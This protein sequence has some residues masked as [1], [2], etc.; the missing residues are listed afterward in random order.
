MP[1]GYL[2]ALC[3]KHGQACLRL[4]TVQRDLKS[5]AWLDI[6]SAPR[7]EGMARSAFG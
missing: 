1:R 2:Q 4:K 5:E 3:R 7:E 6:Y